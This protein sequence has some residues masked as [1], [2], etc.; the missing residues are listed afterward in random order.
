MIKNTIGVSLLALGLIGASSAQALTVIENFNDLN[1]ATGLISPWTSALTTVNGANANTL[2]PAGVLSEVSV[3]QLAISKPDWSAVG[4]PM[5]FEGVGFLAVNGFN[6]GQPNSPVWETV[7]SPIGGFSSGTIYNFEALAKTLSNLEPA[8]LK[9]QITYLQ[10]DG[11]TVINS[12]INSLDLQPS[13][14]TW[15]I[16]GL[17]LAPTA[18]APKVKLTILNSEGVFSGNDFGLDYITFD[19]DSQTPKVPEVSTGISAGVFALVGGLIV[20]RR[21]KAAQ[22]A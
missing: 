9:F 4:S 19:R 2:Q 22:V 18:A 3:A 15:Q 5:N 11:I 16:L 8:N 14:T 13:F 12:G 21:R 1:N 17:S 6:P 7:Y 10:S 20:L